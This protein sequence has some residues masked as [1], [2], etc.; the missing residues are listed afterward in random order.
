MRQDLSASATPYKEPITDVVYLRFHG[1]EKG[2][3]GSYNDKL[4]LEYAQLIK[5]LLGEREKSGNWHRNDS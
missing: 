1:I 4:L 3:H 5:G 2:Y